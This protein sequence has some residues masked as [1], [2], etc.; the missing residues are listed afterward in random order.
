MFSFLRNWISEG[1]FARANKVP[2]LKD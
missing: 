1:S 2:S